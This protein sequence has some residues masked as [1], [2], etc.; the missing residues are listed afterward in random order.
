MMA[1]FGSSTVPCP[2]CYQ[3]IDPN[4][5]GFRCLGRPAPGRDACTKQIDDVRVKVLG[6]HRTVLPSFEP[7][8]RSW[9]RR[10]EPNCPECL[11]PASTRVCPY[12]H[13]VLPPGFS[14]LSQLFG[15]VGVRGSGKTVMLSILSKELTSTIPARFGASIREISSAPESPEV[16]TNSADLA[17][18]LKAIR[19]KLG[20]E[21]DGHL[22]DQTARRAEVRQI[23]A[24]YE[25]QYPP[26]RD[27]SKLAPSTILS[28]YDTSG[29]DLVNAELAREQHYLAA[30]DGL[31]LLLDPFGFVSNRELA[32]GRGVDP[33]S[34]QNTPM[35]I[36]GA[37][38]DMLREVEA[39]GPS[40]KIKRPVAVVLAKIDAFFSQVRADDPIRRP[41]S[42]AAVFDEA[43]SLDLHHHVESLVSEWGGVDILT[44]LRFNYSDYRFFVASALGSE[45]DYK[46]GRVGSRGILP[47]R[48]AEPLLWLMSR[49]GVVPR[50]E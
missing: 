31:I 6:D 37:L 34:L 48:V 36:L 13:S 27:S 26:R 18:R 39:S 20:S 45:P 41:S 24:V 12:C 21:G 10:P 19:K 1:L 8:G 16:S 49:R 32:I 35:E 44:L 22:P 5:P 46:A 50:M 11:G 2:Y 3:R 14:S 15:L 28:F 33:K 4:R 23:P 43:E 30:T 29:E 7:R 42:S 47:H 25:W 38:T 9:I 17:E 40:R